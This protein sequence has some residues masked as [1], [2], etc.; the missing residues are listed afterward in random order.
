MPVVVAVIAV[1]W[2]PGAALASGLGAG[3]WP[4]IALAPVM[5]T[6]LLSVG[7]IVTALVGVRWGLGAALFWVLVVPAAVW[8][9][10]LLLIRTGRRPWR[11]AAPPVRVWELVVGLAVALLI[12]SWVFVVA[13][14]R[15]GNIVQDS[16]TIY[17]LGLVRWMLDSGSLSSLTAD[18][19]NNP[20]TM[21]FY[22]AAFHDVAAVVVQFTGAP[23]VVVDNSLLLVSSALIYPIGLMFMLNTLVATD[24]R[25]VLLAGVL[26]AILPY[27]PWRIMV[28]GALWAQ[29]YG[30][31]LIPAVLTV[32][33]WGLLQVFRRQHWGSAALLF[34]VAVPGITLSHTSAT[35]GVASGA[36]LFSVAVSL[37]HALRTSGRWRWL[38]VAGFVLVGILGPALGAVVAPTG[39]YTSKATPMPIRKAFAGVVTL[40]SSTENAKQFAGIAIVGLALIGCVALVRRGGHDWWLPA[41]AVV[42]F[43]LGNAVYAWGT[44]YIWPFIWPWYS[45]TSRVLAIAGVFLLAMM[46]VGVGWLLSL[47]QRMGRFGIAW[48]VL[49]A[50]ALVPLM[51]VQLGTV[52]SMIGGPYQ[53]TGMWGWIT[54]SK[55]QALRELSH[56]MPADAVVAANPW[57]GG[58]F[59]YLLGP[60]RTVIPTEKSYGHDLETIA[61]GLKNVTTDPEVCRSV[62]RQ[63]VTYVLTGGTIVEGN[64]KW[65]AKYAAID[66]VSEQGGFRQVA[67]AGQYRLWAVPACQE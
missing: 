67:T 39:M 26:S 20:D 27:F 24:R 51:V 36:I 58:M 49:V 50:A 65:Y 63:Q 1:L 30:L 52:V 62:H 29:V 25:L 60:Q 4:A 59:L 8:G 17:H 10:R 54:D 55:A 12:T 22:P 56:Q 5:T 34:L 15:P 13:T 42:F 32:Y 3:R 53:R 23:I 28:W 45:E 35:F 57:R 41:T 9:V 48:T 11:F 43:V 66:E 33:C 46:I 31:L 40:W 7:G 2:I 44:K 38:P 6:S 18:G 47:A 14:V 21:P 64:Q 19:F 37:S 61:A 16:D